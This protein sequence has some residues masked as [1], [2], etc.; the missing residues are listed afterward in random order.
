MHKYLCIC[1]SAGCVSVKLSIC[2]PIPAHL[3]NF[4]THIYGTLYPGTYLALFW[5]P[6]SSTTRFVCFLLPFCQ[7]PHAPSSLYPTATPILVFPIIAL[8]IHIN[9][10]N[11]RRHSAFICLTRA[12]PLPLSHS[13]SPSQ[14]LSFGIVIVALHSIIIRLAI[15]SHLVCRTEITC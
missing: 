2:R 8:L 9:S 15:I 4:R 13:L 12:F 6:L 10:L 11:V 3:H 1:V 5:P 14:S 7:A